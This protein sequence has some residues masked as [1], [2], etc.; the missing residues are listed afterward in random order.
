MDRL[1]LYHF[2]PTECIEKIV[3]DAYHEFMTQCDLLMNN[4]H[5][6]RNYKKKYRYLRDYV[7]TVYQVWEKDETRVLEVEHKLQLVRESRKGHGTKYKDL[8]LPSITTEPFCHR[9]NNHMMTGEDYHALLD[10][11]RQVPDPTQFK[12]ILAMSRFDYLI[13]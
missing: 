3:S 2:Q 5:S 9:C 12:N 7:T 6:N 4:Y 11:S 10:M 1:R 13:R 8:Q